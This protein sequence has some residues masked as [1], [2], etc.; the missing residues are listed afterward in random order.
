MLIPLIP[1]LKNRSENEVVKPSW[2]KLDPDEEF[3]REYNPSGKKSIIA[4]ILGLVVSTQLGVLVFSMC[5]VSDEV[6]AHPDEGAWPIITVLIA[7]IAIAFVFVLVTAKLR[8]MNPVYLT[9][10][11]LV[12]KQK[13][14][15]AA[16]PL[17]DVENVRKIG[18]YSK[19]RV[20]VYSNISSSPLIQIFT[21]SP[22]YV[23]DEILR[24]RDSAIASTRRER[25]F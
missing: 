3:V 8:I 2:L 15:W 6:K 22:G 7:I 11:A 9:T 18:T 10:K 14:N 21:D 1:I 17:T 25:S 19:Y 13:G 12:F 4:V 16:L 20:L 5:Q 23:M 24:Y